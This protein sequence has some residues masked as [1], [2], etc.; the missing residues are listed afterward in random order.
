MPDCNKTARVTWPFLFERVHVSDCKNNNP[1]PA[2]STVAITAMLNGTA[3]PVVPATVPNVAPHTNSAV[4]DPTG[5]TVGS[6]PQGYTHLF[7]VGSTSPTNCTG[8]STATFNVTVTTPAGS[9]TSIPF[10]LSFTCP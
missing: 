8:P 5:L 4:D 7:S 2:G 1:M 3:A 6:I 9:V 10:K